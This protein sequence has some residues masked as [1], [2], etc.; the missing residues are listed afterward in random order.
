M[1]S[2]SYVSA[3]E[4]LNEYSPITIYSEIWPPFQIRNEQGQLTGPATEQVKQILDQ[5]D[6]NYVIEPKRWAMSL[7][8]VQ[9]KPNTLIYSISRTPVREKNFHWIAKLGGVNT[10]L[11]ALSD[12]K[13]RIEHPK[14]L[15]NYTIA[16]KR[17][18][19]STQYFLDM[20]LLPGKNI[21]FVNNTVQALELLNI[22][23]VDFYPISAS[24]LKPSLDSSGYDSRMFK[25]V[26]HLKDLSYDFYLAANIDSDE[27]FISALNILFNH[28]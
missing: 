5:N 26:Y 17:E 28:Q 8:L 27:E 18:E 20:G 15:I 3:T 21:I 16:L 7:N 14:E 22:G 19:A 10:K 23:R 13:I 24:G 2:S 4:S 12:S 9:S 1:A 25:Y 6:V 11:L